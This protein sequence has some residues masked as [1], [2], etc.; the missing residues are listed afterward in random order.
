MKVGDVARLAGV[1][2]RTLHYYEEIGLLRPSRDEAS[3]YRVYT[4]EDLERLQQVL[5]FRELGFD[6][7]RI[8]TIMNAPDFDRHE[9]LL[10]QRRLLAA[11]IARL[12]AT[13]QLV[14]KTL[15]AIQGGYRMTKEEMFEVFGDF[16]PT[17]YEAEAEARWGDTEAYRESI[18]RAPTYTKADW[19][20]FATEQKVVHDAIAALIDQ[21]VPP[22]DPRAMDAVERHRLLIDTWF[23]PCS[24]QFHAQLAKMYIADERFRKTY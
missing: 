22:A 15:A 23:Y 19:K 1:S 9:A 20:R 8:K 5:F 4:D 11:K 7:N 24:R 17:Q 13:L 3:G 18:R 10:E 2:V 16:D 14:E 12:Q 21:G 6:L